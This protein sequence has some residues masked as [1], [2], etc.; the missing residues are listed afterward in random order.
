MKKPGDSDGFSKKVINLHR[1]ERMH[2]H[3]F[4]ALFLRE[5]LIMLRF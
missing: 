5:I 3:S 4:D 1:R 2:L